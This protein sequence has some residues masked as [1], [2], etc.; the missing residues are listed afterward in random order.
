[1]VPSGSYQSLD[2]PK[3]ASKKHEMYS[4]RGVVSSTVLRDDDDLIQLD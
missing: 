4:A 1:M 3:G 2:G